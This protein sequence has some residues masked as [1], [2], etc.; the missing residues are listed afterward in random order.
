MRACHRG[1]ST[2]YV[3]HHHYPDFISAEELIRCIERK[4]NNLTAQEEVRPHQPAPP[5]EEAQIDDSLLSA[6]GEEIRRRWKRIATIACDGHKG[7][8]TTTFTAHGIIIGVLVFLSNSRFHE[9]NRACRVNRFKFKYHQLR[10][11]SV[12]L[13]LSLLALFAAPYVV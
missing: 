12:P 13:C 6:S 8:V 1:L 7:K 9:G 5:Q 11:F 10:S 4:A 3:T 2:A